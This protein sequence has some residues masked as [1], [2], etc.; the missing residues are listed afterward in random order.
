MYINHFVIVSIFRQISLIISNINK[1]NLRLMRVSQYLLMFDLSMR[2]K[3]NKANVVFNALFHFSKFF[4]II[5]KDG[6][7]V[8]KALY[9]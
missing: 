9:E 6:S 3:I 7:R 5:T 1:F 2:Y 4:I 8:L